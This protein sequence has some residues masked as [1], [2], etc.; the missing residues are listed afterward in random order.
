[1]EAPFW[2]GAV[3][4]VRVMTVG[5]VRVALLLTIVTLI[6]ALAVRPAIG[7]GR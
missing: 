4:P 6:A 3:G 1:M 5:A 2:L 7:L